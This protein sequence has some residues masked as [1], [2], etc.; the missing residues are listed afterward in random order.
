MLSYL[1]VSRI[2]TNTGPGGNDEVFLKIYPEGSL[3]TEPLTDADWDLRAAG[4]SGITLERAAGVLQRRR[5]TNQF[6]ELRVATT[7]AGGV[8]EPGATSVRPLP[9]FLFARREAVTRL[10]HS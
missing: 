1:L 8:P 6:D 10:S 2:R 9:A 5:Q 4:N 3:V 7:F